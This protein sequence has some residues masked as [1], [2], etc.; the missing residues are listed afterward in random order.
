MANMWIYHPYTGELMNG[1][2][3]GGR[4]PNNQHSG[5]HQ[6]FPEHGRFRRNTINHKHFEQLQTITG[7]NTWM[8]NTVMVGT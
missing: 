6:H 5:D 7:D 2:G 4:H 3:P 8:F 1:P